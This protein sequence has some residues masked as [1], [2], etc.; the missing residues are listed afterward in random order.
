MPH[1]NILLAKRAVTRE[2]KAQVVREITDTMVRVLGKRPEQVHVV[3]QEIEPEN[4]G[5]GGI[6]TDEWRARA[7][8]AADPGGER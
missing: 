7:A 8:A 1:V 6:L 3:I 2:Q 5:Y 4:W